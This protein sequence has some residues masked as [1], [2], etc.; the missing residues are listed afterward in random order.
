M[1]KD[2]DKKYEE[3]IMK[4]LEKKYPKIAEKLK[5]KEYYLELN[6]S[7]R[8]W[9]GIGKIGVFRYLD[10]DGNDIIEKYKSHEDTWIEKEKEW[11]EKFIG[12]IKFKANIDYDIKNRKIRNFEIIENTFRFKTK[13]KD[14]RLKNLKILKDSINRKKKI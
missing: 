1:K 3:D 2:F 6:G 11:D 8:F 10:D 9:D 13:P 12:V 14:E 7:L 5:N 4:I